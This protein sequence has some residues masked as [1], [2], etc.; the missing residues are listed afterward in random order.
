MSIVD[1]GGRRAAARAAR[2]PVSFKQLCA[3]VVLLEIQFQNKNT[4]F[5]FERLY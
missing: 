4:G 2:A 3:I 5:L 1:S